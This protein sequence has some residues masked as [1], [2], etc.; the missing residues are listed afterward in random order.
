M[1]VYDPLR[2]KLE[3]VEGPNVR[4]SFAELEGILG[5]PLPGSAY[6]FSAWW[7]NN[8]NVGH[9]QARAWLGAGFEARTVSLK[10]RTVEFH[11]I[12]RKTS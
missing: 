4:L 5:K 8:R 7:G 6:R 9:V 10:H 2:L 11:R 12:G 3:T 1:S